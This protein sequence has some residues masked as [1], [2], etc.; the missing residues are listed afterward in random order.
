MGSPATPDGAEKDER[1]G[2]L[3]IRKGILINRKIS[4]IGV[5]SAFILL[6]IGKIVISCLY[7]QLGP[8]RFSTSNLAMAENNTQPASQKMTDKTSLNLSPEMLEKKQ[9]ELKAKEMTLKKWEEE[10]LPLKKEI[11]VKLEELNELNTRL[12]AFAKNLAEREKALH[13]TKIGHLVALY[14]AMEPVR[15][16]AI[17]DKL[18]IE[19]V[20]RILRHMKGKS[21]G[22]TL[23]MMRPERGAVISEKLS[24]L[25]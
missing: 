24:Q 22:K 17:M 25:D 9:R 20:V 10:L 4:L 23:A 3:K 19:T 7:L 8:I 5:G 11:D 12:T 2:R 6:L 21:A 18:K 1:S 16:A 13:D 14:S 15:A